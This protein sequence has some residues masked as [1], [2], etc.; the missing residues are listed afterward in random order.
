M[1]EH[2]LDDICL[3]RISQHRKW[4]EQNHNLVEWVAIL[5]EEIGEA[6]KEA[7]DYHFKNF[8][9][10]DMM[11]SDAEHRDVLRANLLRYRAELIQA[12][13]VIVAMIE[14]LE[15]NE[16]ESVIRPAAQK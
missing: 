15:R 9:L 11:R 3:E 1:N 14:S 8:T 7:V 12:A 16:L 10:R 6:S 2:I 13:A 5:T 4:G